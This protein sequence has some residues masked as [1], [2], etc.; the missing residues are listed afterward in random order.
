MT[1]RMILTMMTD[2]YFFVCSALSGPKQSSYH[3]RTAFFSGFCIRICIALAL[4]VRSRWKLQLDNGASPLLESLYRTVLVSGVGWM[5]GYIPSSNPLLSTAC[6]KERKRLYIDRIHIYM[7][8]KS[9]LINLRPMQTLVVY[10]ANRMK[11]L[12]LLYTL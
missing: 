3:L 5:D 1:T 8:G 11:M 12:L 7:P 6:V 2:P 10:V 4:R 9:K